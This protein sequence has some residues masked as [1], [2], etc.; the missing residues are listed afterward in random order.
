MNPLPVQCPNPEC[1]GPV[2]AKPVRL[3]A[4]LSKHPVAPLFGTVNFGDTNPWLS[5]GLYI[6]VLLS[7]PILIG[8]FGWWAVPFL[9]VSALGF[10]LQVA[11]FLLAP[12]T[13]VIALTRYK[14]KRCGYAWVKNQGSDEPYLRRL[15]W[16]TGR[17]RK[18]ANK[19]M[20]ASILSDTGG[21]L[22]KER[23]D[24][25]RAIPALSESLA[26]RGGQ[27]DRKGLAYTQNNMAFALTFASRP[28]E[29]RDLGEQ[30]AAT[31]R[32]LKEWKGLA[33]ADNTL[34]EALI[35]LGETGRARS[36]LNES[37]QIKWKM[38]DLDLI[39]W[40]LEAFGEIAI[41]EGEH[42]RAAR[43]LG[44]A[45]GLRESTGTR[46][47]PLARARADRAIYAARAALGETQLA[48][49]W[50]EGRHMTIDQACDYALYAREV[51]PISLPLAR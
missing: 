46:L 40:D 51:T 9:I 41:A 12:K 39:A 48:A 22:V 6:V 38:A 21:L 11:T 19:R 15:E 17:A 2:T 26:L 16:M 35:Q 7:S 13:G 32:E 30:S 44:A 24:I 31:F 27:N 28:G 20:L 14:C 8:Y 36:L 49:A 37:L 33:S 45:H 4:D 43:L 1:P 18:S 50:A 29:A 25:A 5:F 23:G 34:A 10:L 42:A 3:L 47:M